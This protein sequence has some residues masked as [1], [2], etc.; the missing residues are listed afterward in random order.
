M[1]GTHVL[2]VAAHP[3]DEA[4]GCGGAIAR[5]VAENERVNILFLAEGGTARYPSADLNAAISDIEAREEAA[6]KAAKVLGAQLP[7]FIRNPDNRLDTV[8]LIDLAKSIEKTVSELK[9]AIIYTHHGGDL[10]VD[11]RRV[12]EAVL[13]ACRP[14]DGHPVKAIYAFEVCSSTEW[15]L[16]NAFAPFRPNHF[17]D[18]A[19]HLDRKLAALECHAMEMRPFPHPR[20]YDAVKALAQFRGAM[21]GCLAAEAFEVVRQVR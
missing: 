10:N 5:H 12:H 2:I 19:P 13:T 20:S 14:M 8:P 17:V 6:R 4:L 15:A 18:I 1:S 7:V 16:S 11:H 9:P 3:D 21:C